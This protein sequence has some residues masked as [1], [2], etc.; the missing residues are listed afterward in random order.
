MSA[1]DRGTILGNDYVIVLGILFDAKGSLWVLNSLAQGVSLLE[2]TSDH[3][4]ISHHHTE[5]EKENGVTADGLSKM[6]FDSR[7]LLWFVN[8]YWNTPAL[9]CYDTNQDIILK[10]DKIVNQ[11]GTKYDIYHINNIAE[12]KEG[13]IWAVTDVGP[14]MIQQSEIGQSNVTFYQIKVPRNDGTN[15]ADYLLSGVDISSIAIDGG[16]RKWFGSNGAG[17]FLISADNIQQEENFTTDNSYL[18]YNNISSIA[19][20]Q[21]SG[22]VFFLSDKGLC[23]YMS[24][25]VAPNEEMT[26]GSV[27]VYPNP[28]TPDFTGMVTITGLSYDADI[29]ITTASGAI[30]AEGRSNGGMFNWDCR[31]QQG[32]RVASGVYMIIT[33][34]SDGNKGTVGKIAVIN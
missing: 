29:K 2:L 30:V 16:N 20:N 11:D 24:N 9:F 18:L 3:Q 26:K 27:N 5:L 1:N 25:A 21:K 10:Y 31:N 22:E 33:A 12:D 32:K 6:M 19:I 14:F 23:S 34:T 17:V 4:W 7:G 13:N 15:Y 28:V 8:N